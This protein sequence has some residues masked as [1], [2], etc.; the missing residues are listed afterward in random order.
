M[1]KG[2]THNTCGFVLTFHEIM[3]RIKAGVRVKFSVRLK[4]EVKVR[5]RVRVINRLRVKVIIV[6]PEGFRGG[7]VRIEM[8][9]YF[10]ASVNTQVYLLFLKFTVRPPILSELSGYYSRALFRR[11]YKAIQTN[12]CQRN[13]HIKMV[14]NTAGSYHKWDILRRSSQRQYL[15]KPSAVRSTVVNLA[16]FSSRLSVLRS[17]PATASLFAAAID[18]FL[19]N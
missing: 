4:F 8:R 18:Q 19:M 9:A 7:G 14:R 15:I 13:V 16:M 11:L 2:T 12:N 5:V 1:G 3:F 17:R 10:Y 6:L